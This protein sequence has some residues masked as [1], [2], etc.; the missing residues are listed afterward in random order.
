MGR[1]RFRV[2]CALVAWMAV[3][4]ALAQTGSGG[5]RVVVQDATTQRPLAGASVVL[6]NRQQLAPRT[7]LVT[8]A[9]GIA[10]FPVLQIGGGYAVEVALAGYATLRLPDL[11]VSSGDARV[12]LVPMSPELQERV[13]VR[14]RSDVID[15]EETAS[16]TKFSDEFLAGLP[17]AGR[18][19][20]NVLTLAPGVKDADGDG[21]PNV[22]GA[23]SR[24]FKAV[25][26]G[27]SN[28]DPL[29]GQ[30][31]SF[32]N[33]DSIE[34][35]EVIP[36]G[37][38]VEFGRA[39]GG[40]ARIVQKQGSNDFEGAFSL[41][42][43][44]G[45]LDGAEDDADYR[46]LQPALQLS[47][48]ILRDRLWYRLSQEFVD[49]EE[50]VDTLRGVNLKHRRQRVVAEQL[51]WQ[52]SPRSKLTFQFQDDPLD[53]ERYD[54]A[55]QTPPDSTRTFRHGGQTYSLDWT[56]PYSSKILVDTLVAY[57]DSGEELIPT[58]TG[59]RQRCVSFNS[60]YRS[61]RQAHCYDVSRQQNSGSYY[62]DWRDKRQR[63]TIGSQ[64]TFYGNLAGMSH[65]V[66]L[67]FSIENE[68]Y[69]RELD[70][71]PRIEQLFVKRQVSFG[72]VTI[73]GRAVTTVAVPRVSASRSTAVNW[74]M[75]AEDQVKLRSNLTFTLGL[76]LDREEIDTIG[77]ARFDP[78][79]EARAFAEIAASLPPSSNDALRN[80][81]LTT[82]TAYAD[83]AALQ[84]G[85][86]EVLGVPPSELPTLPGTS[87]SV[88]WTHRRAADNLSLALT[89]PAARLALAWD[90]W[91]DG[92]TKLAL[93][94]GRYYDKIF[95][96]VPLVETE[97]P[98]ATLLFDTF[99]SQG[100][101]AFA[102]RRPSAVNSALDTTMLDRDLRTP[103]QDETTLAFE[104]AVGAETV[105]R[106][107][108]IDR[109]FKDQL[110]DIDINHV[111]GDFG[112]CVRQI[113]VRLPLVV[114][115]PEALPGLIDPYTGESYDDTDPGP[116]DGRIDDCSGDLVP[117]TEFVGPFEP[118]PPT[119]AIP[120]GLPDQY[121]RNPGWGEVLLLGN[122]NTA[123]YKAFVLE[124]N[125]R[126]YR[127]WQLDGSYTW[128]KAVGDAED[129]NQTL[130]NEFGLRDDEAGFLDYD[131]RHVAQVNVAT[132]PTSGWRLGTTVRWESGLPYSVLES[133]LTLFAIP[134][135]YQGLGDRAVRFRLRYPTGQRND[136]RNPALWTAN[137]R[138]ERE[139]D[140]GSVT[141]A[142]SL[143]VFNMF[144]DRTLIV[145]D[146]T[147]G[148]I[149]G[150]RRAGRQY[151]VGLKLAF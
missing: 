125:R 110:Q 151:Q 27:V 131:Q 123:R 93:T 50:P 4:L 11:R 146:M 52:S 115:S 22:H 149:R 25:V 30:R 75:Y 87:Q 91:N 46:W 107:S 48:P 90:P 95:L 60:I 12:L 70:R 10:L 43:Q 138:V 118:V 68:R 122:F 84:D 139:F 77:R 37:A 72:I 29:T 49:R 2:A 55:T 44:S 129:F 134:P 57:Q 35:L 120:D 28:V 142:V 41:L 76:R 63:M 117:P 79:A 98:T 31:L 34:E 40:F 62:E 145:H 64:A 59:Q 103:Y 92:K 58:T 26:G 85:L 19:Y 7:A 13:E 136:R 119:A 51:T 137:V 133:K 16:S 73:L 150:T 143:E 82:F 74:A 21:N 140:A 111:A 88:F 99:A 61:L 33:S 42:Y 5:L 47:G 39:Q 78:A 97:A 1:G 96:A 81:A 121:V 148:E 20:Q 54:L 132:M 105:L 67:G 113:D 45:W 102:P 104:R 89:N 108:W 130:G 112:R 15:L 141:G 38:G 71:G 100:G 116:G 6:S 56:V 101:R 83:A 65:R 8:A 24:D 147:D 94:A 124:L 18:F 109:R 114:P 14:A 36:A 127:G 69:F 106:V 32:V 135:L 17:I 66:K 128:S 86:A 23:R 3:G 53:I 9:D 80:A 144:D 126:V